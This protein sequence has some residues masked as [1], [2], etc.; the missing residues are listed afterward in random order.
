MGKL[1]SIGL[2]KVKRFESL[3][4]GLWKLQFRLSLEVFALHAHT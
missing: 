4:E 2:Q 3:I 1:Q